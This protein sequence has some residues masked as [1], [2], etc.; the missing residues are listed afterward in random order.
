MIQFLTDHPM[1]VVLTTV[2]VVWIGIAGYLQRIDTRI[3]ELEQS[4]D[5]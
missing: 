1:Y 4:N 5:R 3:S 2:L